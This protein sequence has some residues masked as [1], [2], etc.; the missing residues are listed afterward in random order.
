MDPQIARFLA[1]RLRGG[2]KSTRHQNERVRAWGVHGYFLWKRQFEG[3]GVK[4]TGP[5]RT[6]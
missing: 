3:I 1:A 2:P 4:L 5:I 6:R